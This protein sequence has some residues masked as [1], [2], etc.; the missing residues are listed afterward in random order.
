MILLLVFAM[1]NGYVST[2]VMIAGVSKP[3]LRKDE[4]DVSPPSPQRL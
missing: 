1:S 4:I 3:T 2:L